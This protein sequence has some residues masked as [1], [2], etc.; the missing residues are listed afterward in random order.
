LAAS[1]V[2]PSRM[3][4]VASVTNPAM[5]PVD[6]AD[7]AFASSK[8][9]TTTTAVRTRCPFICGLPQRV[10][11]KLGAITRPIDHSH[12]RQRHEKNVT[13]R[14]EKN[15]TLGGSTPLQPS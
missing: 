10:G 9:P 7:T 15:E 8:A 3:A 4:P 13:T 11:T 2:T 14:Y 1:T 6:W 5:L 12:E